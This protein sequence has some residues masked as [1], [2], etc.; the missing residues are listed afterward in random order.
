MFR[1]TLPAV[2]LT[3]LGLV[4]SAF[5]LNRPDEQVAI[6]LDRASKVPVEGKPGDFLIRVEGR[7]M[8]PRPTY[9]RVVSACLIAEYP[10]PTPNG[11]D[12]RN[13]VSQSA[14]AI[15]PATG[16]FRGEATFDLGPERPP[17]SVRVEVYDEARRSYPR[18]IAF[19]P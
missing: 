16:R 13:S 19:D 8:N 15:D 14:I 5:A 9:R 10:S 6:A 17:F 1:R 3:T 12:P 18:P 4:A 7:A 2:A 11:P